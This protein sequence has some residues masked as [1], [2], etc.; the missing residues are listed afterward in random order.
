METPEDLTP[1]MPGEYIDPP[2]RLK[3]WLLYGVIGAIGFLVVLALFLGVRSLTAPAPASGHVI[4]DTPVMTAA[5]PPLE[6][7]IKIPVTFAGL[8]R[9]P[10]A[11]EASPPP[12]PRA[13]KLA[14]ITPPPEEKPPPPPE[15]KAKKDPAPPVQTATTAPAQKAAPKPPSKWLFAEVKQ[16]SMVQAPPF[17]LPKDEEDSGQGSSRSRAAG[18]FPQATW[19]TPLHPERVLYAASQLIHGILQQD[20]NSDIPS[21][22]RIL[23]TEQVED[24]FFQGNVLVPQYTKLL[25]E[26]TARPTF[27]AARVEITVTRMEFPNGT[28]VD[29]KGK[30]GDASGVAG[31]TGDVDHHWG[32]ILASAGIGAILSIGTRIPAGNQENFAPSLGQDISRDAAGSLAQSTNRVVQKQ[33]DVSPT[34]RAYHGDPVTIALSENISFQTKPAIVSK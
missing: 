32:R 9:R 3:A 29:F 23:V 8:D 7:T 27:G 28:V 1:F 11:S 10:P 26:S 17:P 22:L 4:T 33:L 6:P 30:A 14:E 12:I 19:A 2:E 13:E 5:V 24:M 31:I 18:L 21:T 20:F 25:A 16:G 15:P 34:I